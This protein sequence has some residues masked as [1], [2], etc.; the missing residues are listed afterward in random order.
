MWNLR[1]KET[2]GQFLHYRERIYIGQNWKDWAYSILSTVSWDV[3][4]L[5]QLGVDYLYGDMDLWYGDTEL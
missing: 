3:L 5:D 4:V 2:H 1:E